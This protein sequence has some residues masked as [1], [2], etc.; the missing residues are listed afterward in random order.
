M[1]H[2][3]RACDLSNVV[4]FTFEGKRRRPRNH[5]ESRDTREL[6]NDLFRQTVREVFILL[7]AACVC[8]WQHRDRGVN[9]WLPRLVRMAQNRRYKAVSPAGE[10]LDVTWFFG[11]VLQ[12]IA[13]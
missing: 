6:V 3:Q 9:F 11:G 1:G 12:G 5:F 4:L 8:E 2:I 10:R 7:I 13:Q